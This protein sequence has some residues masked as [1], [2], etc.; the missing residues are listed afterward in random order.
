[1][2][3]SKAVHRQFPSFSPE[4]SESETLNTSL[5]TLKERKEGFENFLLQRRILRERSIKNGR[6]YTPE[7]TLY[8][9]DDE[10]SLFDEYMN[11]LDKRYDD[12]DYLEEEKEDNR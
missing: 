6:R 3:R 8:K 9:D 1:M 10:D 7:V 4:E 12:F 2:E 11:D 5:M